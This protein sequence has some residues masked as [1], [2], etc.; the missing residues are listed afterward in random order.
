MN[1]I[2]MN[3]NITNGAIFDNYISNVDDIYLFSQIINEENKYVDRWLLS[4]Q[5]KS[6]TNK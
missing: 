3:R 4:S 2:N 6:T 1:K 5:R